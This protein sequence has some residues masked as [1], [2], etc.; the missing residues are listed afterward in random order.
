TASEIPTTERGTYTQPT[1]DSST[2]SSE[3]S[4][5]GTPEITTDSLVTQTTVDEGLTTTEVPVEPTTASTMSQ[6]TT[7]DDPGPSLR[8]S[9]D[10]RE[11]EEVTESTTEEPLTTMKPPMTILFINDFSKDFVGDEDAT[12]ELPPHILR[13]ESYGKCPGG[14]YS[15]AGNEFNFTVDIIN[16]IRSDVDMK[17][18]FYEY[19]GEDSPDIY[20]SFYTRDDFASQATGIMRDACF[21]DHKQSN[22]TSF[23]EQLTFVNADVLVWMSAAENEVSTNMPDITANYTRVIGVGLNG[24]DFST[25]Y[26]SSFVEIYQNG[27]GKTKAHI[28]AC[29]IEAL[30]DDID[31]EDLMQCDQWSTTQSSNSRRLN[32]RP[33]RH[34]KS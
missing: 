17:I 20:T 4:S 33:Y 10:T 34:R 14:S 25:A 21:D 31:S 29:M 27:F 7:T 30:W 15:N 13:L 5:Q 9:D 16:D 1:G 26:P 3:S 32:I 11:T 24:A 6:V 8:S 2:L 28:V 22:F 23:G 18:M 12:K 19:R